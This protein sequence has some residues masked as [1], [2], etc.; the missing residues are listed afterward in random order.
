MHATDN[1]KRA[2][3]VMVMHID[4]YK[5]VKGVTVMCWHGYQTF[6]FI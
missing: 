6:L 2:M 1:G 4:G 3:L 5:R